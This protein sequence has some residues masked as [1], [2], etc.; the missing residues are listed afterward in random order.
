MET[1]RAKPEDLEGLLRL[2]TQLHEDP[3]PAVNEAVKGLWNDILTDK[4]HYVLVGRQ[5][6]VIV[7]SCVMIVVP[8]L[9]HGQRPYAL[10]ENVI[11]DA[12]HR[13]RGFATQ[14]LNYARAIAKEKQCY[15]LMLMTGSKKPATISFYEKAGYNSKDK[16]GFIQWL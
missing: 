3:F 2:Y 9:T 4:N 16:T 15:K 14:I 12:G 10:I 11:T 1:G 6:G 5:E 13:N 7:T 8:N